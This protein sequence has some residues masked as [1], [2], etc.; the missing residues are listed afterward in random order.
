MIKYGSIRKLPARETFAQF[1]GQ[2]GAALNERRQRRLG[3]L[4]NHDPGKRGQFAFERLTREQSSL[5]E[6]ISR[7][8]SDSLNLAPICLHRTDEDAIA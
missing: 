2:S 3:N 1:L 5:P 8:Q 6:I 4:I 7:R